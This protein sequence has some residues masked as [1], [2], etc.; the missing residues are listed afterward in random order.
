M[1]CTRARTVVCGSTLRGLAFATILAVGVV[2]AVI[3][4]M[5]ARRSENVVIQRELEYAASKHA[6]SYSATLHDML[7]RTFFAARARCAVLCMRLLLRGLLLVHAASFGRRAGVGTVGEGIPPSF[8]R[9]SRLSTERLPFGVGVCVTPGSQDLAQYLLVTNATELSSTD[10]ATVSGGVVTAHPA[11][12]ARQ[13]GHLMASRVPRHVACHCFSVA[14][15]PT[16]VRLLATSQISCLA[17]APL[18]TFTALAQYEAEFGRIGG[19]NGSIGAGSS[20]PPGYATLSAPT[21][22]LPVRVRAC[23]PCRVCGCHA[24]LEP[25]PAR[26]PVL[27]A[28]R[29]V[30][31]RVGRWAVARLWPGR[32]F[33]LEKPVRLSNEQF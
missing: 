17:Y 32:V 6:V 4:A 13:G 1:A 11:V 29:A 5:Y 18:I 30:C 24:G 2:L 22:W 31:G 19:V 28:T 25:F 10:F 15:L 7:A 12:S 33:K 8:S 16:C 27:F 9:V 23:R 21:Y 14:A 26:F 20:A 3:G